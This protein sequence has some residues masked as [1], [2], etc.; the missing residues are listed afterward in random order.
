MYPAGSRQICSAQLHSM[1]GTSS[2]FFRRISR[3]IHTWSARLSR[4]FLPERYAPDGSRRLVGE[5]SAGGFWSKKHKNRCG[6]TEFTSNN[7]STI[8]YTLST[9]SYTHVGWRP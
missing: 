5:H 4:S 6:P 7:H 9:S 1:P 3:P 8:T 2:A